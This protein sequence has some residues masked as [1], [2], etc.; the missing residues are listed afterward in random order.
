MVA[1]FQL[2][3]FSTRAALFISIA[4]MTV[5]AVPAWLPAVRKAVCAELIVDRLASSPATTSPLDLA[6]VWLLS[7][8]PLALGS[9]AVGRSGAYERIAWAPAPFWG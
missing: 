6:K 9:G 7:A 3:P 5:G 1:P 8:A 2:N 4:A